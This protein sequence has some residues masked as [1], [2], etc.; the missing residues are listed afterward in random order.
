MQTVT[1]ARVNGLEVKPASFLECFR[2][3]RIKRELDAE[4]GTSE[5]FT[6]AACEQLATQS[7]RLRGMVTAVIRHTYP[8]I[9]NS[10]VLRDGRVSNVENVETRT[11]FARIWVGRNDEHVLF[12]FFGDFPRT[13]Y[14]THRL[15]VARCLTKDTLGESQ[16]LVQGVSYDLSCVR[17]RFGNNVWEQTFRRAE[18]IR[19]G[20]IRGTAMQND[21]LYHEF[22]NIGT[23]IGVEIPIE[24]S[25]QMVKVHQDG[26]IQ[27]MGLQEERMEDPATR[28]AAL[29]SVAQVV[30]RLKACE[31]R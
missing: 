20:R 21:P 27:F 18:A 12:K 16:Q 13:I 5:E 9:T 29:E 17:D 31:R 2:H 6:T 30:R 26:R 8:V 24:G 11:D 23:L 19:Q 1:V 7:Q 22:S 28:D 14:P 3:I 10:H 15:L 4:R 25:N